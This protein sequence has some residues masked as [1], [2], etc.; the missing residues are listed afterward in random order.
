MQKQV[1]RIGAANVETVNRG[2]QAKKQTRNMD[3]NTTE[4]NIKGLGMVQ[5]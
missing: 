2:V 3:T 1:T 5:P 4:F